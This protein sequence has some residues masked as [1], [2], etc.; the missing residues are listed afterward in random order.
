MIPL[1]AYP[2]I[3]SGL[4][5]FSVYEDFLLSTSWWHLKWLKRIN[6]IKEHL[7]AINKFLNIG[8]YGRYIGFGPIPIWYDEKNQLYRFEPISTDICQYIGRYILL[9]YRPILHWYRPILHFLFSWIFF[10]NETSFGPTFG[11]KP[12][13]LFPQ[14][15]QSNPMLFVMLYY[16]IIMNLRLENVH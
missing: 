5:Q 14:K 12:N 6:T 11:P 8:R 1:S 10:P 13:L 7:R 15:R 16:A 9:R 4:H 2:P 3:L